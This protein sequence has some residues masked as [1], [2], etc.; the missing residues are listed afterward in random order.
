MKTPRTEEYIMLNKRGF[1]AAM[2]EIEKDGDTIEA[3]K[4]HRGISSGDLDPDAF[5]IGWRRA[6][7]G[8]IAANE[9]PKKQDSSTNTKFAPFE[10]WSQGEGTYFGYTI[11][12]EGNNVTDNVIEPDI[13]ILLD[14]SEWR[15]EY[16]K[17]LGIYELEYC[18]SGHGSWTVYKGKIPTREFFMSLM[19]NVE[20]APK[21][22]WK[23]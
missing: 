13:D 15:L 4:Y 14:Y 17:E 21:I 5:T 1:V 20:D 12:S 16:I 22:K 19:S 8:F 6:C 23:N 10:D 7:D 2:K 9:I 18:C 3:A 11:D